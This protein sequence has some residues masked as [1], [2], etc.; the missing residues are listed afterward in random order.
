MTILVRACGSEGMRARTCAV[1]ISATTFM[2]V[3]PFT[4]QGRYSLIFHRA[5]VHFALAGAVSRSST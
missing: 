1:L 5:A 4:L 3:T 2:E